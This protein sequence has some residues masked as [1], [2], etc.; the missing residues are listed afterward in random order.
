MGLTPLQVVARQSPTFVV[1]VACSAFVGIMASHM[2]MLKISGNAH[3][4]TS[5]LFYGISDVVM[6]SYGDV[7][8]SNRLSPFCSYKAESNLLGLWFSFDV[9]FGL[10]R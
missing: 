2:T 5:Y 9:S 1:G 8:H 6:I 7:G 10:W 3:L 4:S